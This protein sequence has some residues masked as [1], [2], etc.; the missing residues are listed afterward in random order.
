MKGSILAPSYSG[1]KTT[2]YR[3]WSRTIN[4]MDR[5]FLFYFPQVFGNE[6]DGNQVHRTRPHC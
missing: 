3:Y 1:Y 4:I 5:N 6:W 2:R